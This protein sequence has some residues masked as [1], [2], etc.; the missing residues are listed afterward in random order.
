MH[1]RTTELLQRLAEADPYDPAA[2]GRI[3][4]ARQA[5][6]ELVLAVDPDTRRTRRARAPRRL[7][8]LALGAA[9]LALVIVLGIGFPSA[10]PAASAWA[11][12]PWRPPTPSSWRRGWPPAGRPPRPAPARPGCSGSAPAFSRTGARANGAASRTTGSPPTAGPG[13]ARSVSR[14]QAATSPS[15]TVSSPPASR[16]RPGSLSPSPSSRT[17]RLAKPSSGPGWRR[18]SGARGARFTPKKDPAAEVA[19]VLLAYPNIEP[20]QRAAL[21]DLLA[22]SPST[23]VV[24]KTTDPAGR[25]AVEVHF[26]NEPHYPGS[27][28]LT[29]T[30]M[31]DPES[32]QML[33]WETKVSKGDPHDMAG[34]RTRE[35]VDRTVNESW[36]IVQAPH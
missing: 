16:R 24:G 29:D 17:C 27:S 19:L 36:K 18:S 2:A 35:I 11:R 5:T 14:C 26:D 12:S 8:P 1:R 25:P 4:D 34:L 22:H 6:L 32:T 7:W 15:T 31:F 10:P 20:A 21:Y 13:T 28:D 30:F 23:K 33:A 3:A 9:A